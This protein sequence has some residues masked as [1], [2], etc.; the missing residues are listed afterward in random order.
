DDADT[1]FPE[2]PFTEWK[3]VEKES[4]ETDDKHPYAY[5]FLNYNKK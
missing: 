3:L 1:F 2:I 5:T 4:H